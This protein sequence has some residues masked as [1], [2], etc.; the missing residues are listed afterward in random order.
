MVEY[1]SANGL[2]EMDV[3]RVCFSPGE[4]NALVKMFERGEDNIPLSNFSINSVATALKKILHSRDPLIPPRLYNT[5][6]AIQST[7]GS[8]V[9]PK[10]GGGGSDGMSKYLSIAAV[11]SELPENNKKLLCLLFDLLVQLNYNREQ[12][13]MTA[14]QLGYTF[15]PVLLKP[16]KTTS[17]NTV[18]ELQALAAE[19]VQIN[20]LV[21]DMINNHDSIWENVILEGGGNDGTWSQSEVK[22]AE[23]GDVSECSS[24]SKPFNITRWKQHCVGCGQVFCSSC[25]N[26]KAPEDMTGGAVGLVA[27]LV[28]KGM[29][30]GSCNTKFN[31]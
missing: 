11:L 28:G 23:K 24:C 9:K 20:K 13:N 12:T 26:H 6:L 18:G 19:Q 17:G 2:Y 29:L 3:F 16:P 25:C 27:S 1:L 10:G 22:M 4:V 15:A 5:M 14:D 21:I 31:T 30:C 7:S 8:V